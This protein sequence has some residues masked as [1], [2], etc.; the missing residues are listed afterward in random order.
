MLKTMFCQYFWMHFFLTEK[1]F[2]SCQTTRKL[3]FSEVVSLIQCNAAQ[4][5]TFFQI[6]ST[7]NRLQLE[8]TL[9]LF[10][11]PHLGIS[12][13]IRTV[14]TCILQCLQELTNSRYQ[15]VSPEFQFLYI[16]DYCILRR[17]LYTL[18]YQKSQ[19]NSCT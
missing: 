18:L 1:L 19:Q 10:W 12:F 13:R 17:M 6:F 2:F 15:I 9:I 3:I 16:Q 11:R 5:D 7:Y 4:Q 8:I 14:C